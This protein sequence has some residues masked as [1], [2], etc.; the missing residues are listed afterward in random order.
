MQFISEN[1]AFI[2]LLVAVVAVG[3]IYAIR[4]SK[5]QRRANEKDSRMASLCYYRG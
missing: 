5:Q 1:W 3:I 4:C 2:V